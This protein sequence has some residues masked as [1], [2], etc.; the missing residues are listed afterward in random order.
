MTPSRNSKS[1]PLVKALKGIRC[2][3]EHRRR[4]RNHIDEP[5]AKTVRELTRGRSNAGRL[6]PAVQHDSPLTGTAHGERRHAKAA[7][8]VS[9]LRHPLMS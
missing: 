9:D 2:D 3:D 1:P 4:T 8:S 7:T 5:Y 6:R